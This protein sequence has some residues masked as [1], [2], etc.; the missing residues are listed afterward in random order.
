MSDFSMWLN[1]EKVESS[2]ANLEPI[3]TV[4]IQDDVQE[5]GP[6]TGTANIYA[7]RLTDGKS[8]QLGRSHGFF[9]RVRGRVINLD[10]ELFGLNALNHA[11][12]SRFSLEVNADGLRDHLLSSREGVRDS[13]PI[14]E[15][16]D[17]LR[18]SFNECRTAY[19]SW[20]RRQVQMIDID[21]LLSDLAKH[22]RY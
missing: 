6:V 7:R 10:D 2:K 20:A 15:F 5:I 11:A 8:D 14:R 18:K 12:W 22:K 4:T 21:Q 3:K 9:I 19:D 1:G 16:R 17:I 13:E